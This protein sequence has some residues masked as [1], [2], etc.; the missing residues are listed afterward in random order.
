MAKDEPPNFK[1]EHVF[2]GDFRESE[3][4]DQQGYSEETP[5]TTL[6]GESPKSK[7]IATLLS[8]RERDLDIT[9]ISRLSNLSRSSTYKH[10]DELIDF[11]LVVQTR[12]IGG[13]KLYSINQENPII[14]SISELEMKILK[15]Q[16]EH[17]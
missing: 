17:D 13:T 12:Q 14:K 16:F 8:E 7:I 15:Q 1:G 11:G 6:F 3:S 10:I 2:T 9:T 5:L 4:S